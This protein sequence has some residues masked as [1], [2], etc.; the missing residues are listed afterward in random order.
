MLRNTQIV[1]YSLLIPGHSGCLAGALG[2]DIPGC[3]GVCEWVLIINCLA[4][5]GRAGAWF[6]CQGME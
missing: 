5:V 2:S 3:A 6:M 4:K 1:K